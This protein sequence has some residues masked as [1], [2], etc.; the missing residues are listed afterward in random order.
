MSFS[1]LAI[2]H[3]RPRVGPEGLAYEVGNHHGMDFA[4]VCMFRGM[5]I[6]L[7]NEP[8]ESNADST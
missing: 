3:A 8:Q 1:R 2:A 5:C 4:S 6:A 7:S